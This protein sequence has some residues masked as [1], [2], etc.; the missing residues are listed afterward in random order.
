MADEE[1]ERAGTPSEGDDEAAGENEAA[2]ESVP[3]DEADGVDHEAFGAGAGTEEAPAASTPACLDRESGTDPEAVPPQ[4]IPSDPLGPADE[5]ATPAEPGTDEATLDGGPASDDL[6]RGGDLE[7]RLDRLEVGLEAAVAGTLAA[8]APVA[9]AIDRL[10]RQVEEL[11]RL[12]GRDR[13]H[14][15]RLHQENQRLRQG[16][17]GQALAPV[18][19]DLIR[20]A[21]QLVELDRSSS[22]PGRSDAALAQRQVVE[23]LSRAGVDPFVVEVGEAFDAR[24]HQG[25]GRQV[26]DDPVLDGTVAVVRRVGY[27]TGDGGV[28]R[29]AEVEVHRHVAASPPPGEEATP[30]DRPGDDLPPPPVVA[31]PP[32]PPPEPPSSAAPD[33]L[34]PTPE[35]GGTP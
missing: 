10:G 22:D 29:P 2:G 6:D 19:R 23:I 8:L 33:D 1:R 35:P 20:L 3:V 16:E 18:L 31:P 11:A 12:G 7:A 5:G 15:D 34:P 13:D 26:T 30:T 9:D 21:D 24:R 4:E 25:I 28:L 32:A 14:V 17:L 27:R